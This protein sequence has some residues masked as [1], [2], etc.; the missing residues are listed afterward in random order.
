MHGFWRFPA[1]PIGLVL[2][3]LGVG[4]WGVSL[5]KAAEYARRASAPEPIEPRL[6]FADFDRL[7]S[8]TNAM[9]LESLHRGVGEYGINDAKRDF[10]TVVE[11]GGR[12][13]AAL[14]VL[15][16]GIGALQHWRRRA[17]QRL[18]AS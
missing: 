11:S 1:L 4:N 16:A 3:V 17:M 12:L 8:R 7:T 10:Y 6:S 18:A 2:L 14:G 5:P 15:L 13:T 9:V